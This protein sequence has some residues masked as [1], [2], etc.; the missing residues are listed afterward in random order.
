VTIDAV[1]DELNAINDRG[2][3][4]A[5]LAPLRLPTNLDGPERARV[6]A[7]LIAA[8]SRCWKRRRP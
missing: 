2:E 1:I 6:T 7:A 5:F 4:I 8:A 3:L